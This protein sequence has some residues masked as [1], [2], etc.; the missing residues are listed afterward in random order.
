MPIYDYACADCRHRFEHMQALSSNNP[1]KCPACGSSAVS[2]LVSIP[3]LIRT[4]T[5]PQGGRTCC[6]SNERCDRPPCSSDGQC[7]R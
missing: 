3:G 7:H 5:A 6:G 4:S 2:K 1:L